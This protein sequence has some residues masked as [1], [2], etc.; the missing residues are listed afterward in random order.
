MQFIQPTT[1][2]ETKNSS[3]FT[4]LTTEES[5]SINGGRRGRRLQARNMF[6]FTGSNNTVNI[7]AR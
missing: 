2:P 3:L 7:F 1:T 5:V 6:I 4:E